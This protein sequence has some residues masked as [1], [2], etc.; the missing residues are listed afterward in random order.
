M[1]ENPGDFSAHSYLYFVHVYTCTPVLYLNDTIYH[2]SE[3]SP[4]DGKRD[5]L[6]QETPPPM[7]APSQPLIPPGEITSAGTCKNTE[8][9][10]N[11]RINLT[12]SSIKLLAP[13][14]HFSTTSSV[15]SYKMAMEEGYVYVLMIK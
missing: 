6:R 12:L 13:R 14:V 11:T 7:M 4:D 1:V 8:Y 2:I 15:N 10:I 3:T 9:L 5:S